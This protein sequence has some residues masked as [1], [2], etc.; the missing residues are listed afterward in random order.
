MRVCLDVCV[1]V[2]KGAGAGDEFAAP[3]AMKKSSM[4]RLVDLAGSER[5]K[6]TGA[7]GDRLREATNINKSL[8]TLGKCMYV[9]IGCDCTTA[10]NR[11]ITSRCILMSLWVCFSRGYLVPSVSPHESYR[12]V[13]LHVHVCYS[14]ALAEKDSHV[15][16]R[17]S[18]L[19]QLLMNSLG[20]NSATLMIACVSP[21][22]TNF[23]ESQQTLRCE[24]T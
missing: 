9:S 21:A 2:Y 20:G 7:E 3:L 4:F 14:M 19:T 1:C 13:L 18:K 22:D 12:R 6:K 17:D 15:P 10:Y 5:T 11:V 16:Y 8:S 24:H 23:E